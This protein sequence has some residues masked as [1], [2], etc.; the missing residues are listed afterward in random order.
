MNVEKDV[1]LEGIK[2]EAVFINEE[3]YQ[4]IKKDMCKNDDY[5]TQKEFEKISVILA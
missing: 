2:K 3:T 1:V 5:F 4:Q